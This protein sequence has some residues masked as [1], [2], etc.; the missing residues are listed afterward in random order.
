MFIVILGA[1]PIFGVLNPG[2]AAV[3]IIAIVIITAIKDA[4]EDYRRT[5]LDLEVNNTITHMLVN[6]HNPNV[7]EDIVDPWRRFKNLVHATLSRL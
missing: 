5:A 1:F 3:P 6:I 4:I 2:L 7:E